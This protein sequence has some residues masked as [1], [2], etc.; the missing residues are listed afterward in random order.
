VPKLPVQQWPASLGQSIL[1]GQDMTFGGIAW[2]WFRWRALPGVRQLRRDT[3]RQ[4]ALRIL[5]EPVRTWRDETWRDGKPGESYEA[6]EYECGAFKKWRAVFSVRF[7]QSGTSDSSWGLRPIHPA[8]PCAAPNG[9][10]AT[11]LG[12]SGVTEGPP[13]VS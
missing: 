3:S 1:L 10:P 8:Q 7:Y 6:W 4:E 11:Q 13:S 5:G 12:N 9:G 2:W